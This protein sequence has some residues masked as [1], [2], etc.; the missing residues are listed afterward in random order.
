MFAI[1]FIGKHKRHPLSIKHLTV[2]TFSLKKNAHLFLK[3]ITFHTLRLRY[4]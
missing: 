3:R 4:K 1:L 2:F